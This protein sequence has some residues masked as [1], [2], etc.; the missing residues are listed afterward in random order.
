MANM[1][2]NKLKGHAVN[3]QLIFFSDEKNFLRIRRPTGR[4][5]SGARTSQSFPL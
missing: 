4:T 1:L 2:L 3:G 5:S